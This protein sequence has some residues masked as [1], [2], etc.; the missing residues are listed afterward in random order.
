MFFFLAFPKLFPFFSTFFLWVFFVFSP[1]FYGFPQLFDWFSTC[2]PLFRR[3]PMFFFSPVFPLLFLLIFTGFSTTFPSFFFFFF[4]RFFRWFS[5]AFTG[6]PGHYLRLVLFCRRQGRAAEERYS[7]TR[8]DFSAYG[9]PEDQQETLA[10]CC[11][12][13]LFG[14][15]NAETKKVGTGMSLKG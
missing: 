3:F 4:K 5:S 12:Y 6:D 15:P 11:F 9:P 1:M 7:A 2:S 14:D 10:P 8:K 13:I